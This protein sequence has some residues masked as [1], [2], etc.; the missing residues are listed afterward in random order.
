MTADGLKTNA[1]A[2]GPTANPQGSSTS[3]D[4]G[5]NLGALMLATVGLSVVILAVALIFNRRRRHQKTMTNLATTAAART[6]NSSVFSMQ[7]VSS[8][9]S[10]GSIASSV[11]SVA[12]RG[13]GGGGGTQQGRGVR[14]GENQA[15]RLS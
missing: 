10:V 11:M 15:R 12:E 5:L 14:W 3:T 7:S 13:G 2:A 9:Y 8:D 6:A 4:N 1:K